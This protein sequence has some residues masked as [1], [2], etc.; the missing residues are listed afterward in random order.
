LLISLVEQLFEI[1]IKLQVIIISDFVPS[2]G[3]KRTLFGGSYLTDTPIYA[4]PLT[5]L[6][7]ING[8]IHTC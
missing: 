1:C 7:R 4:N 5:N 3:E 6:L 2:N 8:T